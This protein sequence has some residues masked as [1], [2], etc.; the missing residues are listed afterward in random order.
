MWKTMD[1]AT[2][3][4]KKVTELKEV[5]KTFGLAGYDK[6]K[7]SELIDAL[8]SDAP[9]PADAKATE[10]VNAPKVQETEAKNE[11]ETN[12]TVTA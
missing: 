6:M 11:T 1:E 3:K 12:A 9:Q 5:A 4:A 10:P 2:L 8:I 7:K